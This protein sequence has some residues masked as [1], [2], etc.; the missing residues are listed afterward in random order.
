MVAVQVGVHWR[1]RYAVCIHVP[2]GIL[3]LYF[4]ETQSTRS[5]RIF[6]QKRAIE[7]IDHEMEGCEAVIEEAV[8]T[9]EVCL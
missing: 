7:Y 9:R 4:T 5:T 6:E 8:N 3:I 2:S 1:T